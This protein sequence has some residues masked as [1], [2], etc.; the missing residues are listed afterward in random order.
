M[1]KALGILTA[2]CLMV[3]LTVLPAGAAGKIVNLDPDKVEILS[4]GGDR[5]FTPRVQKDVGTAFVVSVTRGEGPTEPG[6]NNEKYGSFGWK[7]PKSQMEETP[8]LGINIAE[9]STGRMKIEAYWGDKA[10]L[11]VEVMQTTTAWDMPGYTRLNL[12][13]ALGSAP[14]GVSEAVLRVTFVVDKQYSPTHDRL[15]VGG[16]C[17]TDDTKTN[18]LSPSAAKALPPD[19]D[20]YGAKVEYGD[21]ISFTIKRGKNADAESTTGGVY[22]LISKAT[23]EENPDIVLDIADNA[24]GIVT[25][26]A[27]FPDKQLGDDLK[28]LIEKKPVSELRG[29]TAYNL[30][31]A[32]SSVSGT[33]NMPNVVVRIFSIYDGSDPNAELNVGGLWLQADKSGTSEPPVPPPTSEAPSSSAPDT[34]SSSEPSGEPNSD[35]AS[36]DSSAAGTTGKGGADSSKTAVPADVSETDNSGGGLPTAG[37]IAII[38]AVVVVLAGGGFAVWYFLVKKKADS[39]SGDPG[40]PP[41]DGESGSDEQP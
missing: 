4:S 14:S 40:T 39:A 37:L 28:T 21:G 27:Y 6:E 35:P 11:A 30:K 7:I 23:I 36:S 34:P 10:D 17:L 19:K 38:A 13:E 16:F 20:V 24:K 41:E 5:T 32:I 29:K 9:G 2:A 22:W 8:Y 25:L 12:K 26:Q 18:P 3:G 15:A 33:E 31:E 1:K